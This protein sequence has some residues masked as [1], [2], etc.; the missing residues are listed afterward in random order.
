MANY[1]VVVLVRTDLEMSAEKVAA[2]VGHAAI[3]AY[4]QGKPTEVQTWQSTGEALIVLKANSQQMMAVLG[5]RAQEAGLDV[6]SIQDAGRT[7]MEPGSMTVMAIGPAE[8]SRIDAVTDR[9]ELF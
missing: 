7:E 8:V 4:R 2:Q 5:K 9:L 1:K 6:N 3:A